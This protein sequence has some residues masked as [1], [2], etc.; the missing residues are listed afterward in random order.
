VKPIAFR[1]VEPSDLVFIEHSYLDSAKTSH[2]SGLS[3]VI[4]WD[5]LHEDKGWRERELPIWRA[6]LRRPAL[7]GVAA[8]KPGESPESGADLYGYLLYEEGYEYRKTKQSLPLPLPYV[9]FLYIKSSYRRPAL[10]VEER[11]FER[12]GI[13][14]RQPFHWAVKT[15]S[16]SRN[17]Y[18][19]ATNHRPLYVRFPPPKPNP[20]RL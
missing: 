18:F 5:P 16:L 15:P 14:P 4:P 1:D 9:V 6:I 8:H 20:E 3:P 13:D 12:A 11:L 10:R 2:S 17:P 7:R 19:R